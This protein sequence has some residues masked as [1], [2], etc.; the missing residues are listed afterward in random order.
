[1]ARYFPLPPGSP[2]EAFSEIAPR[3]PVFELIPLVS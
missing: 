1:V 3:Y 2:A